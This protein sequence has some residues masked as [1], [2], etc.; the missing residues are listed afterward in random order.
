MGGRGEHLEKT[1]HYYN[2]TTVFMLS[3]ISIFS[4]WCVPLC[5]TTLYSEIIQF[6]FLDYLL[7][8][9]FNFLCTFHTLFAHANFELNYFPSLEP[10]ITLNTIKMYLMMKK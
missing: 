6:S 9:K 1:I 8:N 5:D 3:E 7:V 10:M 4:T 2:Q